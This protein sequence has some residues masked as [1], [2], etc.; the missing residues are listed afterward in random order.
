MASDRESADGGL[1]SR[2]ARELFSTSVGID[3]SLSLPQIHAIWQAK[4]TLQLVTVE[5]LKVH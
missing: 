3:V 4:K 5:V 1:D 2:A